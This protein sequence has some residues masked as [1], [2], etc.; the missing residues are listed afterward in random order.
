MNLLV[1]LFSGVLFG[2]GLVVSDMIDPARVIAFLDVASGAW[3]PTLGFVMA[4]AVLPMIIAWRIAA[5]RAKPVYGDKFP[6]PAS[7]SINRKL[8]LGAATF[9]AGWG[10]VGI[11]PGPAITALSIGGLPVLLFVAC[12]FAG[13]FVASLTARWL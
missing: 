3:D 12:M 7:G 13:F 2:L 9:G 4:G 11:C 10:L 1:S 5:K 6:G 8:I